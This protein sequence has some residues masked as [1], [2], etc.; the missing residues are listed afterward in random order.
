MAPRF[1]PVVL[2]PRLSAGLPNCSKVNMP[3]KAGR[4]KRGK[5]LM[6]SR[7]RPV[8]P[9]ADSVKDLLR[10][11]LPSL[12]RVTDQAARANFWEKWLS[13]RLPPE[14]RSRVSG[15]TEQEGRLTVFA[16]SAVWSARLRYAIAELEPAIRSARPGVTDVAVRVLPRA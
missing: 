12:K 6:R 9:P 10:R 15:V 11:V 16:V 3:K 8:S 5:P 7:T 14:I 1:R 4:N 2:R 13:E